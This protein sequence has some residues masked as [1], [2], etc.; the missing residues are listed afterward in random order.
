MT[1]STN[2]EWLSWIETQKK[3]TEIWF[4]GDIAAAIELIG[5]YLSQS[6]PLD[7]SRQA[8]AFRGDL[9]EESGNLEIA[10]A[11]YLAARELSEKPDYERY[12]LELSLG[13]VAEKL[14]DRRSAGAWYLRALET[15]F[16]DGT[17]SGGSALLRLL[18]LRVEQG[19]SEE[20][21]QLAE[22]VVRQSWRLL[23]VEG[24]PSLEDLRRAAR[25]LI[26]AQGRPRPPKIGP[27]Q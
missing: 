3:A 1:Q 17:T 6:R 21:R 16:L 13:S 9:H 4:A 8:I 15:A 19:L 14:G 22:N 23:G 27:N 12:T 26:E 10:R 7:L 25:K 11:S 2:E 20:E 18:E 24:E 5:H